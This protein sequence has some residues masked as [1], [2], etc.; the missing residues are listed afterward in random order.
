MARASGKFA[1]PPNKRAFGASAKNYLWQS[2]LR[3]QLV[4]AAIEPG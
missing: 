1:S 2:C 4:E 3:N